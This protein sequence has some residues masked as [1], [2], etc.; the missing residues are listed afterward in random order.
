MEVQRGCGCGS[1]IPNP[2][3]ATTCA[4]SPMRR[5]GQRFET[6]RILPWTRSPMLL[7]SLLRAPNP[8]GTPHAGAAGWSRRPLAQLK[9]AR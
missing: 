7:V 8:E 4:G 1:R 5:Y 6:T 9:C 2:E 3:R